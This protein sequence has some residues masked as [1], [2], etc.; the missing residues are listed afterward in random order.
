MV[1]LIKNLSRREQ[2]AAKLSSLELKQT[3]M[4]LLI[5]YLAKLEPYDIVKGDFESISEI[6]GNLE[7]TL[8]TVK[9]TLQKKL[10]GDVLKK[11][12]KKNNL[13]LSS[14][15]SMYAILNINTI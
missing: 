15:S 9:Q 13:A 2:E 3:S 1:Y 10:K 5:P 14:G 12:E 7:Q 4:E 8:A 11:D 6:F